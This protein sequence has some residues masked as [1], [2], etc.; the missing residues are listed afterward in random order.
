MNIAMFT[1]L[2]LQIVGGVQRS[3]A[4][5]KREF[6]QRGHR[7]LVVTP[8]LN[9]KTLK[10]PTIVQVPAIQ[11][12]NG[13]DFSVA[14]PIPGYLTR[15][16]DEFAP[17][18]AHAHHPF[19][20]GATAMRAATKY[21]CPLVFTY[22]TM[23]EQY[24]HY[25]PA[26]SLAIQT[27]VK[28]MAAEYC[29]LCDH[30]IAP[31]ASIAAILRERNV[32]T[33]ITVIP[34]GIDVARFQR[35]DGEA[36][37]RRVGIPPGSFVA[38]HVGRLAREKN[39]VVVAK[40]LIRLCAERADAR[41][42]VVGEGEEAARIERMFQDAGMAD[43]LH[44]PG[45]LQNQ[46]LV[47]AYHAL[48]VF[49]FAS[50]S[51]TQGLVLAE[52]MAAGRPVVALEAPGARDILRDGGNGRL[53]EREDAVGFAHAILEIADLPADQYSLM[54]Q[55]ARETAKEYSNENCVARALELYNQLTTQKAKRRAVA[56][57]AWSRSLRRLEAEWNLW[58]GRAAAAGN[59]MTSGPEPGCLRE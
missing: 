7:V 46:E 12:F 8:A 27:F 34:T 59:A 32:T 49:A 11:N 36:G 2:Y 55:T 18:I 57:N 50:K 28:R 31:C 40:A 5:F 53:L 44:M 15:T 17:D 56:E 35:G 6:E 48:D 13:S 3:I 21:G 19:L 58:S 20:L 51:E 14:I 54:Q 25:A 39:L 33:P 47:D 43:R 41:A 23:W 42:L 10:D 24:L 30:V 16:L 52:A 38:G 9:D 45:T 29:N 37:R 22:H 4:T 1:N 26:D